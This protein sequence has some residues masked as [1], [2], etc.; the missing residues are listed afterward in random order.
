MI[1]PRLAALSIAEKLVASV[2]LSAS[3][4]WMS[5]RAFFS[6]VRRV[7]LPARLR[8]FLFSAYL[9]AL[10]QFV[11]HAWCRWCIGSAVVATLIFLCTLPEFRR[12]E[13][14]T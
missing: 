14:P 9:S 7:D 3:P 12:L 2:S 5:V 8:A 13:R 10:E 6:D 1:R 4:P 11:I